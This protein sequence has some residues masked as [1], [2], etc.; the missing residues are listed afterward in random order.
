MGGALT[1]LALLWAAA[2]LGLLTAVSPCPLATNL[3]ATAYLAR[4][5]ESR[6]KAVLGTLWYTVGRALAYVAV[7]ALLA[8]G[9]ASAPGLSHGLQKWL[10]PMLGP[11][12]VLAAMV[13]LGLLPLPFAAN[14]ANQAS[15]ERWAQRGWL[16]DVVLGF[17]FALSFCPVSAALFFGSLLPLALESGVVMAPVVVYGVATAAPVAAFS[18]VMIFSAR[19]ASRLAGGLSRWQPVMMKATGVLLLVAGLY[20]TLR[21]TL[22]IEFF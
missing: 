6:R 8:L 18:L 11:L 2:W 21:H 13:L 17:L 7:A 10:P 5:V 3:A 20:L 22:G 15:A 19:A 1:T 4:R 12:L 9:L 16:G 14:A